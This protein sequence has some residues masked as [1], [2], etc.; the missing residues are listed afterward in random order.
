M[1]RHQHQ[2]AAFCR[3][4]FNAGRAASLALVLV[5]AMSLAACALDSQLPESSAEA[6]QGGK[7]GKGATPKAAAT[8]TK[9]P[10]AVNPITAA[11]PYPST[12]QPLPRRDTLLRGATVLDGAGH[13]LDNTD[14]LLRDGKIA[15][16]GPELAA[17]EGATVISAT[18]RW[19]TPGIVDPH[20]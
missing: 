5:A 19:V 13:R 9:P 18:G 14:V 2:R 15:A 20:S 7:S 10:R 12:Y 4:G 1:N 8:T 3:A 6:A 11:T 17:P 16:V